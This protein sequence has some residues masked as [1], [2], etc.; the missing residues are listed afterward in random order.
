M[1]G[2]TRRDLLKLA[3]ATGA[4]TVG[5]STAARA[6]RGSGAPNYEVINVVGDYGLPLELSGVA[7]DIND[8]GVIVGYVGGHSN[9]FGGQNRGFAWSDGEITLLPTLEDR[10]TE[11]LGVSNSGII[12]GESNSATTGSGE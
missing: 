10:S 9:F 7:W 12:V 8:G 2:Y 5:M 4:S 3:L 6:K 1:N 11:A